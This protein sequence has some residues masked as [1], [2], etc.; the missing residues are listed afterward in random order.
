MCEEFEQILEKRRNSSQPMIDS[1]AIDLHIRTCL[2]CRR[3]YERF[4]M[5]MQEPEPPQRKRVV[6]HKVAVAARIGGVSLVTLAAAMFT[7]HYLGRSPAKHIVD[8][9]AA[10][11]QV[12]NRIE[13]LQ[14][15]EPAKAEQPVTAKPV[16]V[17]RVAKRRS[18]V[19]AKLAVVRRDPVFASPTHEN[20]PLQTISSPLRP[21]QRPDFSIKHAIVH[22]AGVE[23]VVVPVT[24][25]EMS[26]PLETTNAKPRFAIISG[27]GPNPVLVEVTPYPTRIDAP[28]VANNDVPPAKEPKGKIVIAGANE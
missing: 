27:V 11:K 28:Q 19:P 12:M 23:P 17:R 3:A 15:P 24:R 14:E 13:K 1:V 25:P 6:A 22:N 2:A 5:Q 21:A 4:Q 20:L 7:I 8:V 16:P 26:A 10:A 18:S 9:P